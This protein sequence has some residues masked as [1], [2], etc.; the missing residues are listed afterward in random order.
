MI[1]RF[2]FAC[3]PWLPRLFP[4]VLGTTIRITKQD[5]IY[6]GPRPGDR[7]YHAESLPA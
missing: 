7:R 6:V 1:A 2:V 3:G 4:D 5:V